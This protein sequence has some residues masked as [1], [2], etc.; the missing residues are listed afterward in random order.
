ME[1]KHMQGVLSRI[2]KDLKGTLKE[3]WRNFKANPY[4]LVDLNNLN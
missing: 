2:S 3:D 1:G 4:M